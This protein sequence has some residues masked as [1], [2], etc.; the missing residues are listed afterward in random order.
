MESMARRAGL[1]R[2]QVRHDPALHHERQHLGAVAHQSDRHGLLLVDRVADDAHGLIEVV[3]HDVAVA[4]LQALLDALRVYFDAQAGRAGHT[5]RK[6]LRSAH[7]AHAAGEQ[8]PAGERSGEMLAAGGGERFV[9]ALQNALRADIDP[10]AGGHLAVHDEAEL[11]EFAEVV[12]IR[13][14]PDDIRV[15]D[16]HAGRVVVRAE[17]ADGLAGLNEKRLVVSQ[18]LQF[19]HDGMERGPVPSGFACAAVDHQVLRALAH[20]GVEVVHQHADGRFLAPSLGAQLGAARS[21]N[22]RLHKNHFSAK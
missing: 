9:G 19:A 8:E 21:S 12:P 5:G 20:L 2:E 16:E 4:G 13:P 1:V 10:T 14:V 17:Y 3:D 7:S 22:R 11:L 15:R 18:V 6:R